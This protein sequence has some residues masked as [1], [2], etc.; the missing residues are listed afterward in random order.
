MPTYTLEDKET[1]QQEE[2]FMNWDELQEYKKL[3]PHLKQVIGAPNI[4]GSTGGRATKVENH[5]FKE[6]LQ[7]VGEAFPGSAVAKQHTRR[8]SKEVK[9]KEIVDKHRKIQAKGNKNV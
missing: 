8:T 9:T 2:V 3:N 5:P 7:K 1:G 6:V 4:I